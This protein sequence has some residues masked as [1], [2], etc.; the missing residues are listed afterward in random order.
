MRKNPMSIF[1]L[2]S[3]LVVTACSHA[4]SVGERMLLQGADSTELGEKWVE[5]NHLIQKGNIQIDHGKSMVEKG[6]RLI[7]KGHTKIHDGQGMIEQGNRMKNKSETD[8]SEKFSDK[9]AE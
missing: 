1:L 4:P 6:E 9:K 3:V 7:K 8:F 2:S 5:G